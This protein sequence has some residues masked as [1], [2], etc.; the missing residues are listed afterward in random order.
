MPK[1]QRGQLSILS[2]PGHEKTKKYNNK[3]SNEGIYYSQN[4]ICVRDIK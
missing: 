4:N 3:A 1:H 2:R